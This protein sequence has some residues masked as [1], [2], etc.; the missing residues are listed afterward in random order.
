MAKLTFSGTP[1]DWQA[2]K[3]HLA[4]Q[5]FSPSPF[6]SYRCQIEQTPPASFILQIKDDMLIGK[7]C[8]FSIVGT[9]GNIDALGNASVLINFILRNQPRFFH[10]R[11]TVNQRGGIDH[12]RL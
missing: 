7:E 5:R 11:M 4:D 3:F 2:L 8:R 10:G 9:F 1:F 12:H 6:T